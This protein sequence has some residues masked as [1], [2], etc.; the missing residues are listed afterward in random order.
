MD[1]NIIQA[2]ETDFDTFSVSEP[3]ENQL[4][5]KQTTI[6]ADHTG[7]SCLIISLLEN[8]FSATSVLH[9]VHMHHR[10][11]STIDLK[12]QVTSRLSSSAMKQKMK[13][14]NIIVNRSK[15]TLRMCS[16]F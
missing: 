15:I 6:I 5:N 12:L 10:H 8:L 1:S 4:A 16:R 7:R 2:F 11:K 3:A 9:Q 14:H 13:L